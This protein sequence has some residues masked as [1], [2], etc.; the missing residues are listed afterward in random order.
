MMLIIIVILAMANLFEWF[1]P[2]PNSSNHHRFGAGSINLT[3]GCGVSCEDHS[4]AHASFEIEGV[5]SC[6]F[7]SCSLHFRF[8]LLLHFL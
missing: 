6:T 2:R 4:A 1:A 5:Y 7:S 8:V 3:V